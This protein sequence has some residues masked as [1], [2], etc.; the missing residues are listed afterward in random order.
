M[1]RF[2][3]SLVVVSVLAITA[4]Q[5]TL[6][7]EP[8]ESAPDLPSMAQA[9]GQV[10]GQYIVVFNDDVTDPPGLA[11]R[12]VAAQGGIL[13]RTWSTAIKGFSATLPDAAAIALGN[14]PNVAYVEPD[15]L[16]GIVGQQLGATWGLDRIDQEDLPLSTTYNYDNDGSVATVYLLDTGVESGHSEFGGRA[17]FIPNGAGGDF[18][19]DT[20][21][22]ANGAED[23]HGHGTHVA[24]T[25]GGETWGVAKGVSI[26]VGRVVNCNGGGLVSMVIDAVDW[27]TANA[28][29]ISPN[30]VVSMSLGY[31]DVQSL[32]TAVQN[33]VTAG[34]HYS[35]AAGNGNFGGRPQDACSESPAGA[36]GANTV[37]ATDSTDRE[38]S[39][40]NYGTCVD[41][42]APGVA[43]TSAWLENGINTISGTSMAT[44][45]VTGAIAL[46]LTAHPGADPSVVST[47]LQDAAGLDKI[48]LHR[49][50]RR[51]GTPNLL[52]NTGAAAG[53]LPENRAP[54]ANDDAA[55]TTE[56]VAVTID[57][58]GNDTDPD[59]DALSVTSAGDGASGT[60]VVN[61]DYTVTYTPNGGI[62]GDDSFTY[63]ISDG[64]LSA[65]ATVTVTVDATPPPPGGAPT[66]T[67]CS[68]DIG[69]INQKV[70]VT[71][72]GTAFVSGATVDFGAGINV[73][74]VTFI[75]STELTVQIKIH[76]R[77]ASGA[78]DVT[79]TNPNG[80]SGTKT[81]CFS[82]N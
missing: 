14:N 45:H 30:S 41:I 25:I 71:V 3:A 67:S 26:L 51:N 75:G 24:G 28:P 64:D 66:V 61:P 23:C 48:S 29:S 38:A 59:G 16:G 68:P 70:P 12:L 79:V 33:S 27:I 58:L 32:R 82:V 81:A 1:S 42:L 53:P 55:L 10:E 62:T 65:S 21:G 52:L 17:G 20:Y 39:F 44:P 74:G 57:V 72:T 19:G 76:R 80:Q 11:R 69:N 50:S 8:T 63:S 47:A 13:G 6:V 34:I 46:Y 22:D 60:T 5:D 15:R 49:T 36:P 56:G 54:K 40:S 9:G 77:A 31:G 43:V 7:N 2:R 73:Q 37:G 78:R 35:V 18:V 4:C